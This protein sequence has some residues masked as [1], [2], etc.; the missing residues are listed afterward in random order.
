MRT[1]DRGWDGI[2]PSCS[3]GAVVAGRWWYRTKKCEAVDV[4]VSSGSGCVVFR[5]EAEMTVAPGREIRF[6]LFF[7]GEGQI[8]NGPLLG[9]LG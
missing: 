8:W 9:E 1:R 5:H 3:G 7:W 2:I 6:L 4:A